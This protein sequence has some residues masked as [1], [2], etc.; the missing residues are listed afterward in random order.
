MTTPRTTNPRTGRH[1]APS[2][3]AQLL[4]GQ[5]APPSNRVLASV[6]CAPSESRMSDELPGEHFNRKI[7]SQGN[8]CQGNGKRR[9]P[10]YSPDNHSPDICPVFSILHPSSLWLRLAALRLCA[11]ALNPPPCNPTSPILRIPLAPLARTVGAL[12]SV[13]PSRLRIQFHLIL[14]FQTSAPRHLQPI[15]PIRFHFTESRQSWTPSNL[16]CHVP[17][18]PR[19]TALRQ[20]PSKPVKAEKE[21]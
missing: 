7:Q 8:L 20:T 18:K 13:V 6:R 19:K 16:T 15:C 9:F 1:P 17:K 5:S 21:V 10:D 2:A 3:A 14:R 11:F 12:P 4:S